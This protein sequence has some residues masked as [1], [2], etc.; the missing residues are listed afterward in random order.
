M[1]EIDIHE[2]SSIIFDCDGVLL[3]SNKIKIKVFKDKV[4][5]VDLNN[6]LR[7]FSIIDGSEIWNFKS[8]NTFLKSNKRNSL[9]IKNDIVLINNS[10]G[11]ISAINANDGSLIWQLP[12][13]SSDIYE[14]AF[15]LIMSDLVSINNDLVFSNN[16]NEFF[17]INLTNG[18]VNW[19]Q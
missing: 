5:S 12:T 13:Q 17:S 4:Y 3:D 11:D 16:R 15:N 19:K 6:V 9:I 1:L 18:V 7:C 8:E 2:N 10:L 14:S